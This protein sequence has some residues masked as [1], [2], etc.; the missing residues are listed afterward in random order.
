MKALKISIYVII[1]V[2]VICI[3][4]IYTFASKESCLES[5]VRIFIPEDCTKEQLKGTLIETLGE[6][7]DF[8]YKMWELSSGNIK[9]SDGSYVIEP[10]EK[11]YKVAQRL[12]NGNQ[13]PLNVTLHN[14]RTIK[15][16]AKRLSD[17]LEYSENDYLNAIDSVIGDEPQF[18]KSERYAAAFFPDSYNFYWNENP[19]RVIKKLYNEFSKFWTEERVA[20]AKNLGLT[21]VEVVTLASIV[22]SES[23]KS[24]EHPIIARLY[25]NRLDKGMKL[26]ADPTVKFA[27]GDFTLRRIT[28]RHLQVNSP[29]NTYLYAGLP[30]GPIRIVERAVVDAVLNAPQNSYLYMCAKE[31]FSGYHNFASNYDQHLRNAARYQSELNR[32]GIR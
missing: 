7:G 15:D 25:L 6:D 3:V 22:E 14:M 17:K 20:K 8:V 23:N 13:T 19:K 9:R 2:V 24:D 21:P 29:Y 27:V 11:L 1:S 31:D 28:G 5:S 26:Q 16:L 32:R 4:A 12:K 30:P 10:G 18:E